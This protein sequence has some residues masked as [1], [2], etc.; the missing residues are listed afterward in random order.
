MCNKIKVKL[1]VLGK[2]YW[3]DVFHC[4]VT[5]ST[6]NGKSDLN[7]GTLDNLGGFFKLTGS[8]MLF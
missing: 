5:G 8:G 7:H 6:N 4:V 1:H 2:V 3:A